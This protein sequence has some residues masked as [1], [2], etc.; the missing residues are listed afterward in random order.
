MTFHVKNDLDGV[1]GGHIG[2][3]VNVAPTPFPSP[4][5]ISAFE[6]QSVNLAAYDTI[7]LNNYDW[8]FNNTE[9][10]LNKSVWKRDW[11]NVIDSLS[12]DQTISILADKNYKGATYKAYLKPKYKISRNDQTEFDGIQSAGIVTHVVEQN[13]GEITAP[14]QQTINNRAYK[15]AGWV[16]GNVNNPRT[17]APQDNATYTALYKYPNHTNQ[18]AAYTNNNQRKIVKQTAVG[19]TTLHN[20]YESMG[21]VWYERSTNNG[22]T[23]QIANNGQ[24]L[25]N[26]PS[27]SPSI[28]YFDNDGNGDD[29]V[30][31]TFQR[32]GVYEN[33]IV[34]VQ[35]YKNG[36]KQSENEAAVLSYISNNY[37]EDDVMPVIGYGIPDRV[38][39][40][41]K[42]SGGLFCKYGNLTGQGIQWYSINPFVQNTNENSINPTIAAKK[43]YTYD[44][45]PEFHL[46][47]QEGESQIKYKIFRSQSP[48]NTI[49]QLT[50]QTLSTGSGYL[51]NRYP[52]IIVMKDAN[53]VYTAR[54]TW[55]GTRYTLPQ[56]I[57]LGKVNKSDN[58]NSN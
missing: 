34:I 28:D 32:I 11:F 1:T 45:R 5:T 48:F 14:L 51:Y 47:W 31:I 56:D 57:E 29:N 55:Q 8:I 13:T 41:Y 40:V 33:P 24:P 19:Q 39:L 58:Q 44:N 54:V 10:L 18:N 36:I 15:F 53:D 17:I 4:K 43:S 25:S 9:A 50:T 26:L 2:V 37:Y 20:V 21:L 42:E 3:G 38:M 23:W 30:L 35:H 27:K 22:A 52:S 7:T 12:L 46:A 6:T 16:D 49:E